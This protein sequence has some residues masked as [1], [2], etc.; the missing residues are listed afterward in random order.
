MP[1]LYS[2]L[3]EAATGCSGLVVEYRTRN[4]EVV[5]GSTLARSMMQAALSKLA[6]HCSVPVGQ[7]DLLPS[8]T[9]ND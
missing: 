8:G 4:G 1:C 6:S 3:F 2:W 9:V 7:L 5:R